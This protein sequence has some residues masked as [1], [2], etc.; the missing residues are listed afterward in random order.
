[1]EH[2]IIILSEALN[3]IE[4]KFY[5]ESL[6]FL[7]EESDITYY[8][9]RK[10]F[11]VLERQTMD[12]VT[13]KVLRDILRILTSLEVKNVPIPTLKKSLKNSKKIFKLKGK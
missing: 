9:L 13:I 6:H 4:N 7:N 5:K 10:L 1:M 2:E 12:P 3:F 11:A 8:E